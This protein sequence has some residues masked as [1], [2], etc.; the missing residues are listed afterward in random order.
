MKFTLFVLSVFSSGVFAQALCPK[1][2]E[3]LCPGKKDFP[4]V[5][6]CLLKQKDRLS[7][8]CKQEVERFVQMREE[9]AAR[10]GG[11]L[12]A[13]GGLNAMG[14]P[15]PI[16]SYETRWSP[17]LNEHKGNVSLPVYKG[18]MDVAAVS[19]A[20]SQL[21]LGETLYFDNGRPAPN[22]LSR[23]EAGA[24]YSKQLL[25]KRSWGLRGS[26]GYAGDKPFAAGK[27]TTYSLMVNYG[28]P[29]EKGYWSLF[30]YTSNNSPILNYVPLPGAAYFYKTAN[31]TGVFGFPILSLQWTPVN[32]WAYSV[33]LF[34][35]TFQA[36]ASYG[37][38][39]DL[40]FFIAHSF[41]VQSY[42]P[43]DRE[44][45]KDRL[46]LREQKIGIGG[47]GLIAKKTM[48]ELQGGR[49]MDRSMYVGKSF[50]K[51]ESGEVNIPDDWFVNLIIKVLL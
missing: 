3:H 5:A 28:Y 30:A 21:H 16:L 50:F 46:Y 33:S 39:D 48:L 25:E 34:G 43:A 42:M 35:P 45:R 4:E 18:K 24:Q 17:D 19:L 10:G 40:Q 20:G 8:Q 49:T 11:S 31:F 6:Q 44:E 27:D 2:A 7:D 26:V 15:I 41:S 38:R 13:F 32:P 1:E 36:E 14:P 37:H 47:R 9:A 23:Y 12:A 22:T 51:K 29:G